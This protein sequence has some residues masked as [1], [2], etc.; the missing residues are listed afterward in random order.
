MVSSRDAARFKHGN[1]ELSDRI[2]RDIRK[3][4]SAL[5]AYS[6][7]GKRD[8]LLDL[9]PGLVHSYGDVAAALAVE[10]FEQTTGQRGTIHAGPSTEAVQA[11][12]RAVI[13][14]LWEGKDTEAMMAVIASATRH[15]LQ[16]GRT[17][18]HD[19]AK[20]TPGIRFARVPDGNACD[21]CLIMSSRGA[22]YLTEETA[23]GEGN[24]YHDSDGCMPLAV[25]D[26]DDLPY[27]DAA[28]Y[29]TYKDAWEAAGGPG[30][31]AGAVAREMRRIRLAQA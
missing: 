6:P 2:A 25:Q 27:D 20:Y 19:S 1:D 4:W 16:S 22:V 8:A 5:G 7:S 14:G 13:G 30:V 24:E 18:I 31:Q 21:W 12:T 28:L 10:Y 3:T 23:G 9:I 29:A 17:T 11:S 15:M 26:G